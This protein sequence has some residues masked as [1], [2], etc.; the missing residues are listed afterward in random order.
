[1]PYSVYD[2]RQNI[3]LANQECGTGALWWRQNI[4]LANQECGTGAFSWKKLEV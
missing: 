2:W 4:L 1:V 3:L